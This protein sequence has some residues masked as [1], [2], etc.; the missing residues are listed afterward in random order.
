MRMRRYMMRVSFL[1]LMVGLLFAVPVGT[2][3]EPSIPAK[4]FRFHRDH[5]LGTSMDL[6]VLAADERLA[7]EVERRGV[8]EG[9]RLAGLLS[10]YEPDSELGRLNR[11][12]QSVKCS[13]ELIQVLHAC[14]RWRVRSGGAFNVQAA[15]IIDA[16]H[17]AEKDGQPPSESTLR[18]IAAQIDARAWDVEPE[19]GMARRLGEGRVTV[20]ALAKGFIVDRAV[21]AARTRVSGITGIMLDIGGDIVTWGAASSM[22][23]HAAWQIGVADPHHPQ[24]NAPPLAPIMNGPGLA[25]SLP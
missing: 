4:K 19:S 22:T 13:P 16:W 15:Q 18:S 21:A 20:D 5:V 17:R 11:C 3:A 1:G 9:D 7:R 2:S 12:R 8:L 25:T 14:E 10:T 23:D 6:T 24:D